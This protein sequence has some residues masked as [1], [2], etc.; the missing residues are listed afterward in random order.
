MCDSHHR[1][2]PSDHFL[3]S[4]GKE[5]PTL[6]HY[7]IVLS[8]LTNFD[9]SSMHVSV[10]WNHRDECVCVCKHTHTLSAPI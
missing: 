7:K 1:H 10:L 2:F 5:A 6:H 4:M 9:V 8:P 3:P